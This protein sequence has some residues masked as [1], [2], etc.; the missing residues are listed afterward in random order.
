MAY[1]S[2][3]AGDCIQAVAAATADPLTPHARPGIES[4]LLHLDSLF[5][6]FFGFLGLN[7]QHMEVPRLGVESELPLPAYTTATATAV[8]PSCVCD[9][10]DSSW[11]HRILNPQSEARDRI[12]ILIDTSRIHF[13]CAT[14]RT[15]FK[16]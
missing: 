4:A 6:F 14:V 5:F 10:H 13:C 9:L 16:F 11:Q 12:R 3:R 15:P 7:L 1:G 2:S 8:P